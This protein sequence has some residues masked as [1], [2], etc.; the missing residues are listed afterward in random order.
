MNVNE[1]VSTLYSGAGS[2]P[3]DGNLEGILA[4]DP[5]RDVEKLAVCWRATVESIRKSVE[6]K[7]DLLLTREP[8]YWEDRA[9][10]A[11]SP[12]G[13]PAGNHVEESLGFKAKEQLIGA[14]PITIARVSSIWE[15]DGSR[16]LTGLL[17]ALAITNH[18]PAVA[19]VAPGTPKAAIG[20]VA[21]VALATFVERAKPKLAAKSIRVVGSKQA[22]LTTLAVLPGFISVA[23][24]SSLLAAG[25]V[26]AVIS[27]DACEWEAFEYA[28][29]WISAG[30]GKALI[31]LGTAVSMDPGA[32][33]FSTWVRSRLKG[34]EVIYIPA[35]DPFTP[36]HTEVPSW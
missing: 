17:E 21:P 29:D 2:K 34:I 22:N 25:V 4:G 13:P 15:G 11:E 33:V 35:G 8:L 36:V 31:L 23:D 26:D 3:P 20:K 27:G 6:L 1:V 16:S 32:A 10:R 24:L 30:E 5:A 14:L 9:K 7:C 19:P 28:E 12:M 18:Q